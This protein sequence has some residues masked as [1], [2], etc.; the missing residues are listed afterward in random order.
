LSSFSKFVFTI[1]PS[2]ELYQ[3][4]LINLASIKN[5]Q[6]FNGTSEDYLEKIVNIVASQNESRISFWLDGHFSE[7]NTFLGDL[8]TPIMLEL[9]VIAKHLRHFEQI[10]V[11]VDDVRCFLVDSSYPPLDFLVDWARLNNLMWHIEGD[12]FIATNQ[13][14]IFES[15]YTAK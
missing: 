11:L 8:S 10:T 1:E 7:G 6:V 2:D 3:Q 12:I 14:R 13:T 4:S 5:I 15:I 9:E